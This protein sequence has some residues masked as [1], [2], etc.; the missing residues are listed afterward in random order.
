M[1]KWPTASWLELSDDE[2]SALGLLAW[3]WIAHMGTLDIE[4]PDGTFLRTPPWSV[5]LTS[6]EAATVA[7]VLGLDVSARLAAIAA[8]E[9]A[10]EV[11]QELGERADE[12]DDHE[13]ELESAGD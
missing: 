4:H 6:R 3:Q 7:K 5:S 12:L 8:A 9:M 10:E 11:E 1:A 2:R 13:R